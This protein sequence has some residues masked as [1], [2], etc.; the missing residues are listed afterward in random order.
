MKKSDQIEKER[1]RMSKS[2][3]GNCYQYRQHYTDK[4]FTYLRIISAPPLSGLIVD[5]FVEENSK[6]PQ[7][8][9]QRTEESI[10]NIQNMEKIPLEEFEHM[11]SE[12]LKKMNL[13]WKVSN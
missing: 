11:V 4:Y 5:T 13:S 1:E 9:F 12:Y 8:I 7:L 3:V 6:W 10:S 2:L